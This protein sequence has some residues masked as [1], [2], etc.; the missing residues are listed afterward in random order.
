MAR[1][2]QG[3]RQY[4]QE[5]SLV[6]GAND[7]AWVDRLEGQI[8]RDAEREAYGR[9]P[10]KIGESDLVAELTYQVLLAKNKTEKK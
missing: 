3:N 5:Q 8:L 2:V 6:N 9:R 10:T 4:T 1:M 7:L